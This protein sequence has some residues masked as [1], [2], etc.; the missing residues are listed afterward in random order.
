MALAGGVLKDS[1]G[2]GKTLELSAGMLVAAAV[3]LW[4]LRVPNTRMENVRVE[5]DA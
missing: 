3:W 5:V 2:L 4:A 1:I